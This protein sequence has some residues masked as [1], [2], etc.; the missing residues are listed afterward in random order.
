MHFTTNQE[1]DPVND[2]QLVRLWD[3]GVT[4]KD[5][6][7]APGQFHWA[8]L[9]YLLDRYKGKNITLCIA[10]TPQWAAE[11]PNEPHYAP[12]LGPGTNSLPKDPDHTWKPFVWELS[13]RYKGRI[14]SYEI[15][16]EPQLVDFLGASFWNNAGRDRLAQM[17]KDAGRIIK[18]N[19]PQA[20][21]GAPSL[22]PRESS[23]GMKRAGKMLDALQRKNAYKYID[24]NAC[25]I[26]PEPGKG[27]DRWTKYF[28]DV[29]SELKR[30]G[31]P[32]PIRVTETMF[33]LLGPAMND[34]DIYHAIRDTYKAHPKVWTYWYAWDR[35]D[36]N[37][38]GE[39]DGFQIDHGRVAW[40]AIKK[41]HNKF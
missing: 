24:W 30:R 15:W 8:R 17:I 5:L 32:G 4:W 20:L 37:G 19:D 14:H 16:N 10:A 6:H 7:V 41:Y 39:G 40:E 1:K 34:P 12:W 11:K 38:S 33:G 35:M 2:I 27:S 26:Y 25:H 9:D 23:G 21:I 31:I 13:D 18:S 22:L 36:L 3:D 28:N 29:K